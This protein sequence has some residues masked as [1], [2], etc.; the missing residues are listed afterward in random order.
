MTAKPKQIDIAEA[1]EE[2]ADKLPDLEFTSDG[3][4]VSGEP[5][6]KSSTDDEKAPP[7]DSKR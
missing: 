6:S 5:T 4:L 3:E 1:L 7:D 2:A